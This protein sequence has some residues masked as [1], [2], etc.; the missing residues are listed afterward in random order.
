[1]QTKGWTSQRWVGTRARALRSGRRLTKQNEK[2]T[3]ESKQWRHTRVADMPGFRSVSTGGG[4]TLARRMRRTW[5]AGEW[6]LH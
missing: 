4:E 1:M 5:P 6:E 3:K 2:K